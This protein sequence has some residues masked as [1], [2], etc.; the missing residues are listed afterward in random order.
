MK[1]DAMIVGAQKAGTTSV[2]NYLKAHP[3]INGHQQIEFS[4]FANDK[5]YEQDFKKGLE[6]YVFDKPLG[7]D[8]LHLAKNVTICFT[9][10]AIKRLKE[11][12]PECKI[13]LF[14]R[15]PVARA[16]SSYTMAVK[17]GWMQEDFDAIIPF[18]EAK[19]YDHIMYRH[20]IALGEYT[21]HLELILKY[22]PA[23]QIRVYLFEDLKENTEAICTAIF[24]WLGVE[25]DFVP[26][27]EKV[28]N[29]TTAPRS[30]KMAKL[31]NSLRSPNNKLRQFVKAILP[32]AL[33][34]KIS[35]GVLNANK[36]NKRFDPISEEAKIILEK[37]YAP[38][39]KKLVNIV[40]ENNLLFSFGHNNW[41]SQHAKKSTTK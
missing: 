1:I 36:S 41:L 27:L 6:N 17:D 18:M 31:I 29:P 15:E 23:E 40:V 20:F 11:H 25:A 37:Y 14:L 26:N 12:N 21:K 28:H 22:F 24:E 3:R 39:N 34:H 10:K 32:S 13:L 38:L 19:N 8:F 2:L 30:K 9:E 35:Q 16:Y 4:Y 5:E 33:F 7:G